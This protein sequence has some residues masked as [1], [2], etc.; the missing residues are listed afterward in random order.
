MNKYNVVEFTSEYS[1][2]SAL[3]SALNYAMDSEITYQNVETCKGSR[4]HYPDLAPDYIEHYT[5][6]RATVSFIPSEKFLEEQLRK[7]EERKQKEEIERK[8]Q[9]EEKRLME[10]VW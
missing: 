7:E 10:I 5:Y 6:Y 8:K 3:E 2:G 4:W 1:P 9:E